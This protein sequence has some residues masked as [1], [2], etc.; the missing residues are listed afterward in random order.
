MVLTVYLYMSIL[1]KAIY[2]WSRFD[3]VMS[4]NVD[5]IHLTIEISFLYTYLLL[6]HVFN[7]IFAF[8]W[9]TTVPFT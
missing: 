3:L 1:Y 6:P 7:F 9:Q 5:V 4:Y 2:S 8:I